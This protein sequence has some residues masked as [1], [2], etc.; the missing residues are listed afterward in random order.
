[1]KYVPHNRIGTAAHCFY[2]VDY[3][4]TTN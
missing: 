3:T 4:P 2:T 1:M